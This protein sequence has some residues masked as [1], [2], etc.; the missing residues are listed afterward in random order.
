MSLIVARKHKN[1]I[2]IVG[3]TRVSVDDKI[4]S[5]ERFP[6]QYGIIK[7]IILNKNFCIS[8]AGTI[9]YA[10]E[11]IRVFQQRNISSF[12]DTIKY[13]LD[14][15]IYRN[16]EVEFILSFG[17]PDNEIVQIKDRKSNKVTN[18]WIGDHSAY[19]KFQQYKLEKTEQGNFDSQRMTMQVIEM[20]VINDEE[21]FTD[22]LIAL[23]RVNE[24]VSIKTVGDF[25]TTVIYDKKGFR[26]SHHLDT[27]SHPLS[28]ETFRVGQAV[29]FGTR[30][31]G[32]Y[33]VSFTNAESEGLQVA[34][35]Y[36]N[37]ANLGIIYKSIN[38]GI[39]LPHI[40]KNFDLTTFAA[41]AEKEI[42]VTGIHTMFVDGK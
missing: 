12:D 33:A 41:K 25:T 17:V 3:D 37:Q 2:Y 23:K 14:Y 10:D 20:P 6:P 29:P 30:E 9:D 22:M 24:D 19:E 4:L 15:H 35:V 7:S 1:Q 28:F 31:Q 34:I 39:L 42:G 27:V 8:F 5:T 38:K 16:E 40:F 13:F 36:I 26:F 21:I 11:A 32:G 18:A